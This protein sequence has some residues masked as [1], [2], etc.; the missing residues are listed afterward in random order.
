MAEL[1]ERLKAALSDRYAIESAEQLTHP[2]TLTLM[3]SGEA[4][5]MKTV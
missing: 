3:D 4:A 1:F 5:R 2:H